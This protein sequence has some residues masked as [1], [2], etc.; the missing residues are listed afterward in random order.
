M[1]TCTERKKNLNVTSV[2]THQLISA[3]ISSLRLA[4][5]CSTFSSFIH[6]HVPVTLNTDIYA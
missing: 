1:S 4:P 2:I 3:I 5:Q 6:E